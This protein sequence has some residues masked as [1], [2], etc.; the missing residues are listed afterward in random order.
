MHRL[1]NEDMATTT[2]RVSPEAHRI[3]K[4]ASEER[5]IS[6]V[7]ALDE[8]TKAW[9]REHF[10]QEFNNA[11]ATLREN[12]TVWAEEQD[13]RRLWDAAL[14]DNIEEEDGSKTT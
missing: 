12:A 6:L 3:L 11:Y 10:F 14:T 8:I 5:G 9:E 1:K 2:I 4:L 13:E 7:E